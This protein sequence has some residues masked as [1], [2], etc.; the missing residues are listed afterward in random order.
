MIHTHPFGRGTNVLLR[1]CSAAAGV[2]VGAV[3]GVAAVAAVVPAA[4]FLDVVA[5]GLVHSVTVIVMMQVP[6]A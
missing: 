3:V 2:V 5:D 1:Q 6:V 4:A